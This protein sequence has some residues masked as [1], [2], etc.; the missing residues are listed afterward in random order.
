MPGG[1][2][3][4]SA[5]KRQIRSHAT[6]ALLL[7]ASM[8]APTTFRF[9]T[10]GFP[11]TTECFTSAPLEMNDVCLDTGND[12]HVVLS[13]MRDMCCQHFGSEEAEMFE[14]LHWSLVP[15][16]LG[17]GLRFSQMLGKVKVHGDVTRSCLLFRLGNQRPT[18]RQ[19]RSGE[20]RSHT[21]SCL[22]LRIMAKLSASIHTCTLIH[23]EARIFSNGLRGET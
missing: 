11:S 7:T 19:E 5:L 1:S 17:D 14:I 6:R 16:S 12:I 18:N 15:V 22:C 9:N 23:D 2:T 3:P 20:Q 8:S 10:T 21:A 4:L 13:D